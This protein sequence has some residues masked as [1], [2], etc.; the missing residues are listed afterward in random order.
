MRLWGGKA[1]LDRCGQLSLPGSALGW[2]SQHSPCSWSSMWRCKRALWCQLC[3][4]LC[5]TWVFQNDVWLIGRWKEQGSVKIYLFCL[6]HCSCGGKYCSIR[7]RNLDCQIS[8]WRL[9]LVQF[10]WFSR[11]GCFSL[12]SKAKIDS[13][14]SCFLPERFP[15]CWIPCWDRHQS[16]WMISARR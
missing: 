9:T 15:S 6:I 2:G 7:E 11:M 5:V 8:G 16:T 4:P 12:V 14:L 1:R 13:D 3:L 10:V